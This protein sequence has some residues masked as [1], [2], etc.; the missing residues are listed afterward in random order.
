VRASLA[1]RAAVPFLGLLPQESAQRHPA[2]RCGSASW[3]PSGEFSDSAQLAASRADEEDVDPIAWHLTHRLIDGRVIAPQPLEPR[4][5]AR[6]V[7]EIGRRFRLLAFHLVDTH[8]H[9]LLCCSRRDAGNFARAVEGALRKRLGIPVAFETARFTA[10]ENQRHLERA[11]LYIMRQR[12]RHGLPEEPTDEGSNLL[13]LRG[14][15]VLGEYTRREAARLMPRLLASRELARL[16]IVPNAT[17]P[18]PSAA[19]ER[20]AVAACIPTLA[21]KAPS[22]RAARAA[23]LAALPE[24]S[25]SALSLAMGISRSTLH[26]ARALHPPADLVRAIQ[27][28]LSLAEQETPAALDPASPGADGPFA[29]DEPS[30]S[31]PKL[32]A[33]AVSPQAVPPSWLVDE[34]D[35][36]GVDLQRPVPPTPAAATRATA[37]PDTPERPRAAWTSPRAR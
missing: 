33:V 35:F 15:R 19:V 21:G 22:M 17:Q 34:L 6:V 3:R 11:F 31:P 20:A 14:L 24:A 36:D 10:V 1:A 28:H 5:A 2:T 13:D 26:R 25:P 8:L 30:E 9:T 37:R 29:A 4:M 27:R 18:T 32:V 12:T 23:L 16:E 7:L